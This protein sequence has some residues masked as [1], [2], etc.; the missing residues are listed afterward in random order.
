MYIHA[1]DLA[2][3]KKGIV[4]TLYLIACKRLSIVLA[5]IR[6]DKHMHGNWDEP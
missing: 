1:G 6:K 3:S 2:N 5:P 4:S